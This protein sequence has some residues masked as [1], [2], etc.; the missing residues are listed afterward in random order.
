MYST[1]ETKEIFWEKYVS[2]RQELAQLLR[3]QCKEFEEFVDILDSN[4]PAT[5][6]YPRN[7]ETVVKEFVPTMLH[8]VN[9]GT[10]HRVRSGP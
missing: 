7:E 10:H 6:S 8:I 4:V 3:A 1:K 2:D 9:H 5:F